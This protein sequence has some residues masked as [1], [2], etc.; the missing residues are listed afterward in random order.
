[1]LGRLPLTWVAS[2]G[3]RNLGAGLSGT[4][5][6]AM[7]WCRGAVERPMTDPLVLTDPT[8]PIMPSPCE[9]RSAWR[10]AW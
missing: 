8:D 4:G 5:T 7:L 1:M 6:V 10:R 9:L 3:I 2:S